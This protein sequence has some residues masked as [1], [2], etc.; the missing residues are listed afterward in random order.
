MV[1]QQQKGLPSS[2]FFSAGLVE[3]F[4]RQQWLQLSRLRFCFIPWI[5]QRS[6]MSAA[7]ISITKLIRT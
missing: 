1:V 2:S 7:Y 6:M 4:K 3:L 5:T